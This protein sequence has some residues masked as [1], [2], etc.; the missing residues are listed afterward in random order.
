MLNSPVADFSKLYIRLRQ[1]DSLAVLMLLPSREKLLLAALSRPSLAV[2]SEA[3]E[4][5]P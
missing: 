5:V 3:V 1:S 2:A 4:F